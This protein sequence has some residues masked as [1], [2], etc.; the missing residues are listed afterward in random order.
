MNVDFFV[1][2]W[3]AC[4]SHSGIVLGMLTGIIIILIIEARQ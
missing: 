1:A 2:F 4:L 3:D